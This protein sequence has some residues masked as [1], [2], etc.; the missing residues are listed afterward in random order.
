MRKKDREDIES[1]IINIEHLIYTLRLDQWNDRRSQIRG[2][3]TRIKNLRKKLGE[4]A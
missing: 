2:L 4:D 1:K 3:Q